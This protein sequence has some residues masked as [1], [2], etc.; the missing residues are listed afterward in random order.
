MYAYRSDDGLRLEAIPGRRIRM[1]DRSSLIKDSR[2]GRFVLFT[3]DP[4]KFREAGGRHISRSESGDF[5]EWSKP[6]MVLSPKLHNERGVE[7]YGVPVFEWHGWY[8]GLLEYGNNVRDV[9]EVHLVVSRDGR[10][11][12]RPQPDRPFIAATYPWNRAWNTVRQQR[13]GRSEGTDG[14]LFRRPL[15]GPRLGY[16]ARARRDRFRLAAVGSV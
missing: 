15:A 14:V 11:W 1:G 4:D 12:S 7:Y 13:P 2:N 3:R 16:R 8:F 10:R 9:I 6:E 5:V